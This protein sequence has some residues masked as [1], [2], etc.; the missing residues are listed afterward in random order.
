M[1]VDECSS[2]ETSRITSSAEKSNWLLN[3]DQT[4]APGIPKGAPP[5]QTYPSCCTPAGSVETKPATEPTAPEQ[6][7]V[8][9]AGKANSVLPTQQDCELPSASAAPTPTPSAGADLLGNP[10]PGIGQGSPP[11]TSADPT[12]PTDP[13]APAEPAETYPAQEPT[14]TNDPPPQTNSGAAANKQAP[15]Q[16]NV[17]AG[18]ANSVPPTQQDCA[19][20][21]VCPTQA[22]SPPT[23]A[24]V[25]IN[26]RPTLPTGPIGKTPINTITPTG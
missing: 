13:N 18:G 21:T 26:P 2:Y 6:Q 15:E 14:D 3:A 16:Q 7:D 10:R 17:D 22:P 5:V 11:K 12:P 4:E 24:G 19:L 23:G 1:D 20:P 8:V 25:R 9:G